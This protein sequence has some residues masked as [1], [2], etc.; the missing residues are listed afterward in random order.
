MY[1]Y[2]KKLEKRKAETKIIII[3]IREV[4]TTVRSQ[5][6]KRYNEKILMKKMRLRMLTN[7]TN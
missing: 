6:T 4:H 1:L 2:L 3:R 7:D 5:Y